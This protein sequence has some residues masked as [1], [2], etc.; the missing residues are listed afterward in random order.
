MVGGWIA[1]AAMM[2]LSEPT[3]GELWRG[4]RGLP[5]LAEILVWLLFF[6]FVLALGIW[7]SS[8]E[9]WLRLTLVG[10]CAVGWSLVFWP[11]TT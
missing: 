9:G 10:C 4:V 3:L 5:F 8:W 6:P 11:R 1:F 2:V 7:D